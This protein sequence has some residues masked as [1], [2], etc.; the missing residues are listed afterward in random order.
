MSFQLRVNYMQFVAVILREQSDKLF[1]FLNIP[2][3][4]Q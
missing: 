4:Y 2:L 3:K 1:S